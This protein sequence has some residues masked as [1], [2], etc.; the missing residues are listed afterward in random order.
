MTFIRLEV[1]GIPNGKFLQLY[2]V[3]DAHYE[4]GV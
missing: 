4:F 1:V 2:R 3:M